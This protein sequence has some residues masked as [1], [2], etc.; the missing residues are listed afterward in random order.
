MAH[1]HNAAFVRFVADCKRV[2]G[3]RGDVIRLARYYTDGGRTLPALRNRT[4]VRCW[5][6]ENHEE[7]FVAAADKLWREFAATLPEAERA[8]AL[9]R[10]DL[11]AGA[12]REALEAALI[13]AWADVYGEADVSAALL[14]EVPAACEA[15]AMMFGRSGDDEAS[16]QM[17]ARAVS[18][19]ASSG[20]WPVRP[21]AA[22]RHSKVMRWRLVRAEPGPRR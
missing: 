8:A 22:D 10:D 16:P 19:I 13:A 20:R 21:G 7:A 4:D 9:S 11:G 1:V 12:R 14:C 5:A 15:I 17:M 6:A 18:Q 2:R 3:A